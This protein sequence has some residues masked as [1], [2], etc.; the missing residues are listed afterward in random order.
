MKGLPMMTDPST[1]VADIQLTDDVIEFC[2]RNA[3][4]DHLGRAIELAKQHFS[5]VGDPVV[6]LEQDPEVD[7]RYLVLEIRVKGDESESI[8]A[9]RIYNR[10]WTS[11]ADWPEV[12]RISLVVDL[13]D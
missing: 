2:R 10:A 5:V 3:L 11:S 8:R 9:H 1:T 4:L 12:S 13:E 7:E 6:R